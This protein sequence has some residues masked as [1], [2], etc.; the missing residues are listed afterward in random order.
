M[1]QKK[2]LPLQSES[3]FYATM[4]RLE[5]KVEMEEV[6]RARAFALS[7]ADNAG[8][9][10]REAQNLHLVVEEAVANIVNYSG[11]TK[12][13]LS[14]W[15]EDGSLYVS[16]CDDGMAFDPTR[17]PEP[18]LTLPI[19]LRAVGGLGIHYIRQMT[20][21]MAYRRQDGRNILT[22]RKTLG[23]TD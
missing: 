1:I 7:I 12:M 15:Q 11:A 23:K 8:L 5:L 3:A 17:H 21:G 16:F 14:A 18:D 20:D 6:R 4:T 10:E 22:V 19:A 2:I 9:S 13:E